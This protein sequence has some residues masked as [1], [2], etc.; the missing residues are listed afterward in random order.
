MSCAMRKVARCFFAP[1]ESIF[2]SEFD[3]DEAS[4]SQNKLVDALR[5]GRCWLVQDE[6]IPSE[7]GVPEPQW[8]RVDL[9]ICF[10]PIGG[11]VCISR[12]PSLL[13]FWFLLLL[14]S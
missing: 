5:L 1:G 11:L 9:W 8:I 2:R 6:E 12:K 14:E 3:Y 13:A 10:P 7:Q 4:Q